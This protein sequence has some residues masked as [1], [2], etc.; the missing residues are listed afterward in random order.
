MKVEDMTPA[1]L[2]LNSQVARHLN[3]GDH[4]RLHTSSNKLIGTNK[5][6]SDDEDEKPL[7]IDEKKM[8]KPAKIVPNEHRGPIKLRLSGKL[9][10]I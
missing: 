5:K 4:S 3:K 1:Y 9:G 7:M 10:R 8:S 6:G 2:P